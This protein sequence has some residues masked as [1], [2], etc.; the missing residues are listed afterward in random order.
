MIRI[1]IALKKQAA[2]N[3]FHWVAFSISPI[4]FSIVK[5]S[6]FFS[7]ADKNSI[8]KKKSFQMG[9]PCVIMIDVSAGLVSGITICPKVRSVPAPSIVAASS[10]A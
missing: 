9:T 6:V 2:N 4:K 8:L 7:G 5:G 3:I 1:G 10:S